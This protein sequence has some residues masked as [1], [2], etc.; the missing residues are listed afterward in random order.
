MEISCAS[1]TAAVL[2]LGYVK[3]LLNWLQYLSHLA[4]NFLIWVFPSHPTMLNDL[5]EIFPLLSVDFG[6]KS[7]HC[8]A[9]NCLNMIQTRC[10]LQFYFGLNVLN[11]DMF[12]KIKSFV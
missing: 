9:I 3:R 2:L 10:K 1:N 12:V 4:Q 5:K 6:L 7:E 11:S 8:V